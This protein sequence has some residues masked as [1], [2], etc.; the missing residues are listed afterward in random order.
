[1]SYERSTGEILLR[2]A[3]AFA[4]LALAGWL[5]TLCWDSDINHMT[6]AERL[7]GNF[8]IGGFG[9]AIAAAICV[10]D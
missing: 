6:F 5:C 10:V 1:M 7:L 4:A 9:L 2:G 8:F 3:F